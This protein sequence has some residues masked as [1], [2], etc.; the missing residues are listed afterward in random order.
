MTFPKPPPIDV[1]I[2][3]Q[4]ECDEL[5][6]IFEDER[7]KSAA[8]ERE[9]DEW[10]AR[11]EAAEAL[12]KLPA[13]AMAIRAVSQAI[14]TSPACTDTVWLTDTETACDALF[15]IADEIIDVADGATKH[16]EAGK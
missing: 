9:R 10:K 12:R 14:E 5:R 6:M 4:R 7:K 11:T 2:M 1:L 3:R 8:I 16:G 15:R 13:F